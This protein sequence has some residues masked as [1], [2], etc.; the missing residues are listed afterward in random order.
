MKY[1]FVNTKRDA[2]QNLWKLMKGDR[3]W[4]VSY[5]SK[6][7]IRGKRLKFVLPNITNIIILC[8][9][10]LLFLFFDALP[11]KMLLQLFTQ[12]KSRHSR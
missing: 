6:N 1:I 12:D 8:H 10:I 11:S 3:N 5:R 7:M 9:F 4:V 2:N